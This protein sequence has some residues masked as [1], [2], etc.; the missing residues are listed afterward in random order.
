[1]LKLGGERATSFSVSDMSRFAHYGIAGSDFQGHIPERRERSCE[2]IRAENKSIPVCDLRSPVVDG[3]A[4]KTQNYRLAADTEQR[5]KLSDRPRTDYGGNRQEKAQIATPHRADQNSTCTPSLD[6]DTVDAMMTA[7]LP[8][9]NQM[10]IRDFPNKHRW[11]DL[12]CW[13]RQASRNA[14]GELMSHH[15]R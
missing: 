14:L 3:P 10:G 7:A 13:A 15:K 1:M 6:L 4:R 5:S 11:D 2:E 12:P 8:S 9:S